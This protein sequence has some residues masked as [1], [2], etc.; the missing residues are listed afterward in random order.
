VEVRIESPTTSPLLPDVSTLSL[1]T[2]KPTTLGCQLLAHLH[3]ACLH[4]GY[5]N[6]AYLHS[7]QL[8]LGYPNSPT[9]NPTGVS[10]NCPLL[11]PILAPISIR[12]S[13]PNSTPN[14][15]LV[16]FLLPL[17]IVLLSVSLSGLLFDLTKCNKC[18][19]QR[20]DEV[21]QMCYA[22]PSSDNRHHKK[23]PTERPHV[24]GYRVRAATR[25][26]GNSQ[27]LFQPTFLDTKPLSLKKKKKVASV[28]FCRSIL[29]ECSPPS[30]GFHS[31]MQCNTTCSA[32]PHPCSATPHP[33]RFSPCYN[34]V[35]TL[36]Q[37]CCNPVTT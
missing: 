7:G 16:P 2:R 6:L 15:A 14:S 36:L 3:L 23:V 33:N 26:G 13:A 5:Q 35:S 8:R 29:Y 32:T 19:T 10:F 31:P 25:A 4:L 22:P 11:A 37:P 1:P 34:P 24:R 18:V 30:Q 27:P 17:V 28:F 20:T 9:R 21:F 12:I